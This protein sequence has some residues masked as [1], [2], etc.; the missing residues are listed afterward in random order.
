MEDCGT[1]GRFGLSVHHDIQ[2]PESR[3]AKHVC[4][5]IGQCF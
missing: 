2:V 1:E 4:F 5:W 3:L